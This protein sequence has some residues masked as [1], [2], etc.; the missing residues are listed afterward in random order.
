MQQTH[1][2]TTKKT[3][4]KE[5]N[6]WPHVVYKCDTK[7]L[8]SK[9]N[10]AVTVAVAAAVACRLKSV[11]HAACT[12]QTRDPLRCP[13]PRHSFFE[14]RCPGTPSRLGVQIR[15]SGRSYRSTLGE[16]RNFEALTLV[17]SSMLCKLAKGNIKTEAVKLTKCAV[18]RTKLVEFP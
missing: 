1:N 18:K 13:C 7:C 5:Q 11:L 14:K 8:A 17:N 2:Q 10:V 12:R 6:F 16:K 3:L 9:A 4:K 15:V